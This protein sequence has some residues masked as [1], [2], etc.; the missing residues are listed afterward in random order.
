[1]LGAG[2]AS[3]FESMTATPKLESGKTRT[4]RSNT[5]SSTVP[6]AGLRQ[7]PLIGTWHSGRDINT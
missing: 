7:D 5:F 4:V 6:S 3:S 2:L 1:M